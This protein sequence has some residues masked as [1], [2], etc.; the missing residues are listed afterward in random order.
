MFEPS[1]R[2]KTIRGVGWSAA[3]NNASKMLQK[4]FFCYSREKL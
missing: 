3:D 4:K 1:L 2:N